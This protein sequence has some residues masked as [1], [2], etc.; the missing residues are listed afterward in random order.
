MTAVTV[1]NVYVAAKLIIGLLHPC[2]ETLFHSLVPHQKSLQPSGTS[3]D[4]DVKLKHLLWA[5]ACS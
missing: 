3:F 5:L 4:H 2:N 1:E